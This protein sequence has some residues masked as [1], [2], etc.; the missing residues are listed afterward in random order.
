M[1]VHTDA[2]EP[3]AH[4]APT[5]NLKNTSNSKIRQLSPSATP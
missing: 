1:P 5:E 3:L 4:C 2:E